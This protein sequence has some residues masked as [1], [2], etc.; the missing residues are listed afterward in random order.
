[1]LFI[2]R[3]NQTAW[4]HLAWVISL[5]FCQLAVASPN[6]Q[7]T[8]QHHQKI[9]MVVS[10]Y[11]KDQGTTQPGYEFDELAKSYLTFRDNGVAVDIAS[12]QGGPVEADEYDTKKS[13]NQ[14]FLADKLAVKKLANTLSLQ[15]INSRDYDAVFVVGGKGAMFDLPY[16]QMLQKTIAD[17][18]QAGGSVGAVC[19]GPAALVDVKLDNGSYLVAGKKVNGFTNVEEQAFG[20]K[21]VKSFDFLLEDKLKER[22][23]EFES[24]PMMLSHVAIDGRLVT[25][26]NPT[27]TVDTAQALLQSIGITPKNQNNYSDDMTLKLVAEILKGDDQA[28]Q[29]YNNNKAKYEPMMMG[30]YGFMHFMSADNN[31]AYRQAL[32]LMQL[33]QNDVNHPKL[34]LQIAKAHIKL[35]QTKQAKSLLLEIIKNHPDLSEASTLLEQL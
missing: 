24:S 12:P 35:D 19:H 13:Y 14:T 6:K 33:A 32:K 15:Q 23:A 2:F 17:I 11:G 5:A 29:Q 26:Q 10:G 3:K 9:L 20:K 8:D 22:Q 30:M 25:G 4:L 28:A 7:N 27:S 1:M 31:Q 16:D 18:Y 21:W 34:N